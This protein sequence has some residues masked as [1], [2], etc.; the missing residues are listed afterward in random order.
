MFT[1]SFRIH[2]YIVK[3]DQYTMIQEFEK[4]LV[5][6]ALER[7]RGTHESKG[8]YLELI[9]AVPAGERGFSLILFSNR[10]LVISIT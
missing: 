2:K 10:D 9:S 1:L 6:D 3:V 5:H 4:H 7:G 8:H